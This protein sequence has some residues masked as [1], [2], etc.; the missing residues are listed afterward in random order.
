MS[1]KAEWLSTI[2]PAMGASL[3]IILWFSSLFA[4]LKA[5]KTGTIGKLNP[6]PYVFGLMNNIAWTIYSVILKNPFIYAANSIGVILNLYFTLTALVLLAK[7]EDERN[8]ECYDK[9]E[10][11]FIGCI[12]FF[13]FLTLF[14]G[15]IKDLMTFESV[16]SCMQ[17][18][19]LILNIAYVLS[20]NG[21]IVEI[22]STKD[23]SGIYIPFLL[24]NMANSFLWLFYGILGLNNVAIY[25]PNILCIICVSINIFL[26]VLWA[27]NVGGVS[28][29]RNT[30]INLESD[31]TSPL[32][33]DR[34]PS[35]EGKDTGVHRLNDSLIRTSKI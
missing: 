24:V 13:V 25:G 10:K 8:K 28:S 6:Y 11:F 31:V 19:S 2:V 14:I 12:S 1:T 32:D 29:V 7:N 9:V 23:V 15:V 22:V 5:K 30:N 26:K 3:S 17:I 20:L 4:F 34:L 18:V 16:S 27:D 21:T 33:R 35:K